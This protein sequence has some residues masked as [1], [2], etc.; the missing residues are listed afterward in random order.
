MAEYKRFRFIIPISPGI[1]IHDIVLQFEDFGAI[2]LNGQN[3][4]HLSADSFLQIEIFHLKLE[5]LKTLIRLADERKDLSYRNRVVDRLYI[6]P[7][8]QTAAEIDPRIDI[9]WNDSLDRNCECLWWLSGWQRMWTKGSDRLTGLHVAMNFNGISAVHR[10][11]WVNVILSGLG[12]LVKPMNFL[13]RSLHTLD[14]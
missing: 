13:A 3:W 14:L 10:P 4:I 5:V 2:V 11:V 8:V 1:F 12:R 7:I 6:A 9:M